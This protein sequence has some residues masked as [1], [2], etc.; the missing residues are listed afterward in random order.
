MNIAIGIMM[1]LNKKN[2]LLSI[3]FLSFFLINTSWG[4][5]IRDFQ[6]EGISIGDS[7]LDH[8]TEDQINRASKTDYP[9]SK[10][11]QLVH[12][13][14][15]KSDIYNQFTIS[16]KPNDKRYIIYSLGGDIHFEN[17][18]TGCLNKK[19]EIVEQISSAFSNAVENSYTHKYTTIDDGKSF[20]KVTDLDFEDGSAIRVYCNSWTKETEEKRNFMDMLTVSITT[21]EYLDWINYEAYD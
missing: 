11:Y 4:D 18:L 21:K 10:K 15:D 3:L 2:K 7:A 14:T 19:K 20:S 17:D 9:N 6:I 5:D 12:I 1:L 13:L 8:F 16:I